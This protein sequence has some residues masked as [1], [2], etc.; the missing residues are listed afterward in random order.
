MVISSV[1]L[2]QNELLIVHLTTVLLPSVKPVNVVVVEALSVITAVPL[3]ILQLPV[4]VVGLLPVIVT[5]GTLHKVWSNPASATVGGAAISIVTSSALAVHVPLLIVQRNVVLVPGVKPVRIVLGELLSVIVHVP[6]TILHK[7]VPTI[8]LLPAKDVLV[9]LHSCW[10]NPASAMLGNASFVIVTSSILEPQ[11]PLLIVH[12]NTVLVP[13]VKPVTL[14]VAELA[15]VIVHVPLTI[16]HT[17]VPITGVLPIM[18][19][20]DVLHCVWSAPASASVA[21]SDTSIVTS[22]VVAVHV[23]LLIVQRNV[24][25]VPGTKSVIV[26]TGEL[27]TAMVQLPVTILQLPT[28]TPAELADSAVVV[29]LHSC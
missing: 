6:L 4:P 2:P 21:G 20:V 16:L 13:A 7:P 18:F 5:V 3:T 10:S 22:S 27:P 24:V 17:P 23:P 15:A 26:V 1:V 19:A 14:V 9:T 29:V 28:P 11:K 12:L 25:V 8:G